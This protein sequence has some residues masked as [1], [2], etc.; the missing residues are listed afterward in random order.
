[1]GEHKKIKQ[2]THTH[3]HSGKSIQKHILRHLLYQTERMM[4]FFALSSDLKRNP[5][6]SL[7]FLI[8]GICHEQ[9][10][11]RKTKDRTER[12]PKETERGWGG[13]RKREQG[14]Q[15]GRRRRRRVSAERAE[16]NKLKLIWCSAF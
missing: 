8:E 10:T 6:T 7:Q 5:L 15:R 9:R 14:E 2:K 13:G 12:E 16:W 3:T 1:M 4:R 11:K